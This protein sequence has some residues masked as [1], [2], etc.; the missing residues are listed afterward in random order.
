[1]VLPL[2]LMLPDLV[3]G[4]IG[5]LIGTFYEL[6]QGA[7][8]GA[9][10][11]IVRQRF[12]AFFDLRVVVDVLLEIE[13]ILFGVRRLGDELT[14][15]RFDDLAHG[16]LH[17]GQQVIGRFSTHVLDAGL[18][19]AKGVPQFL[20]RWSYRHVDIAARGQAVYG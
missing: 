2:N 18:I 19:Q 5:M 15:D 14:V 9:V 8:V 13:V 4:D 10:Q 11:G 6:H 20:G 7:V 1:M 17:R 3:A 12:C 16:S